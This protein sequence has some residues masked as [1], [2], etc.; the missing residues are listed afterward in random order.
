MLTPLAQRILEF[1]AEVAALIN[2]IGRTD[3]AALVR[4]SLKN[5]RLAQGRLLLAEL[6]SRP[7]QVEPAEAVRMVVDAAIGAGLGW[8][9]VVAIVNTASECRV[10]GAR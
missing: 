5:V 10:G 8:Q 1:D 4:R 3:R 7:N 6:A 2:M 9:D